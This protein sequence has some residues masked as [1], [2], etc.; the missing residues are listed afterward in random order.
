[1]YRITLK[2]GARGIVEETSPIKAWKS[3]VGDIKLIARVEV[4][5]ESIWVELKGVV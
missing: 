4:L 3:V 5:R 1:M 2:S